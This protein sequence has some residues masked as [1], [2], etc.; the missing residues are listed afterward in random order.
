M[1]ER[2]P[3]SL[4]REAREAVGDSLWAASSVASELPAGLLAEA[5]AAF[6][7][8]FGAAAMVSAVGV[9]ILAILAAVSLRHIGAIDG[10][11]PRQ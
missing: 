3:E 9:S 1:L 11:E 10:S 6:T 8:G 4:G 5:Q 2:I 7:A